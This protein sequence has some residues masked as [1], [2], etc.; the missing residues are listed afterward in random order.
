MEEKEVFKTEFPEFQFKEAKVRVL[1]SMSFELVSALRRLV[2]QYNIRQTYMDNDEALR[3][4]V[5]FVSVDLL[6]PVQVCPT[7]ISSNV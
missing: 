7:N 4:F 2:E 1:S 6:Y 5:V 3:Q